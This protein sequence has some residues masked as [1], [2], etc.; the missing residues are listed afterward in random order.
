MQIRNFVERNEIKID[1]FKPK[2]S[3]EN[4]YTL[5]GKNLL[6]GEDVEQDLPRAEQLLRRASDQGNRYAS[7]TL[8]KT[9][10]DGEASPAKHPRGDSASV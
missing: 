9:L 4:G 6:R 7:Y 5:L 10:L 2:D 1:R 8:G 3:T